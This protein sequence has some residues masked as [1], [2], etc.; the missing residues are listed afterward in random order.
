MAAASLLGLLQQVPEDWFAVQ[1]GDIDAAAVEVLI[2][3]RAKARAAKD[4]AAADAARDALAN[5]G[6]AIEDTADGT[7]W[8]LAK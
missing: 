8:K 1:I 2:E 6:V 3:T 4:F 5:M 7:I